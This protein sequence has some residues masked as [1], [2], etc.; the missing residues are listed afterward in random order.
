MLYISI[1]E[2]DNPEWRHLRFELEPYYRR[3]TRH[4]HTEYGQKKFALDQFD[5]NTCLD[6]HVLVWDIGFG[7]IMGLLVSERKKKWA[8]I[9]YPHHRCGHPVLR[10]DEEPYEYKPHRKFC[11]TLLLPTLDMSEATDNDTL[12]FKTG[13][14]ILEHLPLVEFDIE[15]PEMA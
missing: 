7:I 2:K 6:N 13:K 9:V 8:Q 12:L 14:M 1:Q 11:S 10:V 15:E 3:R 4:I 5:S